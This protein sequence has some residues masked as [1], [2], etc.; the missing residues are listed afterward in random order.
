[1]TAFHEQIFCQYLDRHLY[2]NFLDI[3]WLTDCRKKTEL[4]SCF[5]EFKFTPSTILVEL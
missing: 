4:T 3:W 5:Q 2:S 1:L